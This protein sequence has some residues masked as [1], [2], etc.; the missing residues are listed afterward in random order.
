MAAQIKRAK[1][2]ERDLAVEPKALEADGG[3]LVAVLV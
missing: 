2:V 1:N 3:Y